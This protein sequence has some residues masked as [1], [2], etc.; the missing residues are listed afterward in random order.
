[1]NILFISLLLPQPYADH[2]SAFTVFK[3]IKHLSKRHDISLISFVL[4][5]KERE[6]ARHVGQYCRRVETVPLPQ[7]R[8]RKL[9][10][11]ANLLTL[12]PMAVSYG[13]SREM[14][15]RIRS[16]LKQDRFDIVELEYTPMGQYISEIR[17]SATVLAIQDV[18][19]VVANRF[20]KSLPFSRKKL[21]WFIDDHVCRRYEPRLLAKFDR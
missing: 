13:Y 15:E 9:W 3:V 16:V 8:F 1:M 4:S 6:L 11:R 10:V 2:A 18:M 7:N 20:V 12:T 14:R 17:S 19:F 5:E 21:E